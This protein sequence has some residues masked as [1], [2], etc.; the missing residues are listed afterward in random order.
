MEDI[1]Y[2]PSVTEDLKEQSSATMEYFKK[3]SELGFKKG[4]F[5]FGIDEASISKDIQTDSTEY[6]KKYEEDR[7][8]LVELGKSVDDFYT[9]NK[10]TLYGLPY[11][12]GAVI[13]GLSNPYDM[14]TNIL[15]G[16]I[17]ATL[18]TTGRILV[19]TLMDVHQANTQAGMIEDRE[20]T[21]AEAGMTVVASAI[22]NIAGDYIGRKFNFA[23]S[24]IENPEKALNPRALKEII[25]DNGVYDGATKLAYQT[26]NKVSY[27]TDVVDVSGQTYFSPDSQ[28]TFIQRKTAQG[29]GDFNIEGR[30]DFSK[31]VLDNELVGN[32][33][34]LLSLGEKV[35][36]AN[37][38]DSIRIFRNNYEKQ[39][40]LV[41]DE[42]RNILGANPQKVLEEINYDGKALARKYIKGV[43]PTDDPGVDKLM[44][45]AIKDREIL[46]NKSGSITIN[47]LKDVDA[48]VSKN[49]DF[50]NA[51]G[52][53]KDL[54]S[55]GWYSFVNSD[56]F[57]TIV[58]MNGGDPKLTYN[59]YL[60]LDEFDAGTII[61][62]TADSIK[63][64]LAISRLEFSFNKQEFLDE[65]GKLF[66]TQY[67][68]LK[69]P[70]SI[71]LTDIGQ[72]KIQELNIDKD[73]LFNVLRDTW[74]STNTAYGTS[75][76]RPFSSL[77]SYFGDNSD[78]MITFFMNVEGGKYLKNNNTVMTDIFYGQAD[79]IAKF[80]IFGTSSYYRI[81]NGVR[82]NFT[83][84]AL[85]QRLG[86]VPS[87]AERAAYTK[88][89]ETLDLSLDNMFGVRQFQTQEIKASEILRSNLRRGTMWFS[90]INEFATNPFIASMRASKYDNFNQLDML[91]YSAITGIRKIKQIVFGGELPNEKF[92]NARIAR[93]IDIRNSQSKF[94]GQYADNIGY[95]FQEAS[96]INIETYGQSYAT[97]KIANLN[98][99]Y[100]L[101]DYE[102][103]RVLNVSGINK[104][105]YDNFLS[106]KD[107]HL[108]SNNDIIDL[109]TLYSSN[110]ETADQLKNIFNYI[111]DD[112]G[113]IN[114][115]SIFR[116]QAQDEIS[117]WLGMYRAFA[118]SMNSDT[119]RGAMY[120]TTESGLRKNRLTSP[121]L[122]IKRGTI[123]NAA[124]L[125]G[126]A[127]ATGKTE[128]II[129]GIAYGDRDFSERFAIAQTVI[130]DI[131]DED[132]ISRIEYSMGTIIKQTGMSLDML[133]S[134]API[135]STVKRA[136][137]TYGDI[138]DDK[139]GIIEGSSEFL[140]K[141][142][143]SRRLFDFGKAT[144]DTTTYNWDD[145]KKV[146][147]FSPEQMQKYKYYVTENRITIGEI[148]QAKKSLESKAKL[149]S[150]RA[151][152][153]EDSTESFDKLPDKAKK[154]YST[155]T[156]TA[157]MT[158]EQI[159]N[160]KG[161]FA[162]IWS[163]SKL[164]SDNKNEQINKLNEG[165]KEIANVTTED[166]DNYTKASNDGFNE[167]SENRKKYYQ[168]LI[169]YMGVEDSIES[170]DFFLKNLGTAKG[171]DAVN[172]LKIKYGV[173]IKAF[174][175]WIKEQ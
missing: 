5:T 68:D 60:T 21:A 125:I 36:L 23:T 71:E 96:Q 87:I 45:N 50:I 131:K 66:K 93:D 56:D 172:I 42:Y 37:T 139:K 148:N 76:Y 95:K 154:Y 92:V 173:D 7:L 128:D 2:N 24:G 28:S 49:S 157:N 65:Y 14:S 13:E 35:D 171:K 113:N 116:T 97:G 69:K 160:N 15:A 89:K 134:E 31:T 164:W 101:L 75:Q 104:G 150:A 108:A 167:L 80:E 19:Q 145:T 47:D 34:N 169:K 3:K 124:G 159:E 29:F 135:I 82:N 147:E 11:L 51:D 136:K 91:G 32:E 144:F 55:D 86:K 99:N 54:D 130:S 138:V 110:T 81:K 16:G 12:A 88:A 132:L 119:L 175:G 100:D 122:G 46:S 118:R 142:I 25:D 106:F 79:E 40:L 162:V 105:N 78:D 26:Q 109:K 73:T 168:N 143:L 72:A 149:A 165:L 112:V 64:D 156:K 98:K 62:P 48:F 114:S 30:R 41:A 121:T 59:N 43:Q 120:Y 84:E 85:L 133:Q 18:P 57:Y 83:N 52:T 22:P 27:G 38:R 140:A 146:Y 117:K 141:E 58:K 123:T 127:Y 152:F 8:A 158:Q 153:L 20:L 70:S 137:R 107:A 9:E 17:S 103:K 67:T 10:D 53:L 74:N 61:K 129:K 174:E 94:S 44:Y 33:L 155:V 166:V 115:N 77:K 102:L 1:Y 90:G 63:G 170:R 161:G 163:E 151:D 126:L 4:L 6:A 111:A 39:S